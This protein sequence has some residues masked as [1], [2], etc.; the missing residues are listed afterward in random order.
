[1][2]GRAVRRVIPGRHRPLPD[3]TPPEVARFYGCLLVA[4]HGMLWGGETNN[5]GYGRFPIWRDGQRIRLLAH[6]VSFMMATGSDPGQL[7]IRHQCDT[8]PCCTPDCFLVGTQADNVRD[9]VIRRR[10][11]TGGLSAFRAIRI[12]QAV[13]R[14]GAD[15]KRCTWCGQVKELADFETARSTPDG[16]AYWC[17]V[18]AAG[19]QF[20]PGRATASVRLCLATGTLPR[21][22]GRAPLAVDPRAVRPAGPLPVALSTR[23]NP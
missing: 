21:A 15:R 5:G 1:M 22:A 23:R 4:G 16:R 8:P 17:R 10:L 7:V 11:D 20:M 3:L 14:T 19:H 13:A 6:R 18:C 9:A 2:G 12:A